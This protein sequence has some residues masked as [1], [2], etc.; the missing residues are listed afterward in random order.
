MSNPSWLVAALVIYSVPTAAQT[1]NPPR[2]A[3]A[4]KPASAKS[5][6][7]KVECR[8]Q[9]SVDNRLSRHSVCLTKQQWLLQEQADKDMARTIQEQSGEERPF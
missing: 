9:D 2:T 6:L 4:A 8:M 3:A 7:D 1:I 5:D